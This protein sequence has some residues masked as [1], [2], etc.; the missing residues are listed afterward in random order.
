MANMGCILPR[1]GV[2]DICSSFARL[3]NSM[4]RC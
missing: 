3:R 2:M 4:V 1:D